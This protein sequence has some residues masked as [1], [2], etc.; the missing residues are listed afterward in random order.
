M[1][2]SPKTPIGVGYWRTRSGEKAY[3][4]AVGAPFPDTDADDQIVGW[5]YFSGKPKLCS[6]RLDGKF[7]Y[8]NECDDHWDLIAPWSE[9]LSGEC[10]A[11]V[12][13]DTGKLCS[14][15][16]KHPGDFS[17]FLATK[18]VKVRYTEITEEN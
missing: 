2:D 1:T 16:P 10:F 3:V 6:W 15:V 5:A 17:L 4:A 12:D 11:I 14:M 7:M 8:C 18:V 13:K 9:P